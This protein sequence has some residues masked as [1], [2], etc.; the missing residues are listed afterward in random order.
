LDGISWRRV[1]QR[2]RCYVRDRQPNLN[3][4]GGPVV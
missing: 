2:S 1:Y 4:S 3:R